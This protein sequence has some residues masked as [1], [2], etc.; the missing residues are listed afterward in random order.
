MSPA[1]S[2]DLAP[3]L[4]RGTQLPELRCPARLNRMDELELHLVPLPMDHAQAAYR[5]L[6]RSHTDLFGTERRQ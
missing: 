5:M 3:A 1:S 2:V 6:R 4:T